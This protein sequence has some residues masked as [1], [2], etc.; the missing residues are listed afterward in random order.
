MLKW[1]KKK[2]ELTKI[3]DREIA[4]VIAYCNVTRVADKPYFT[5][6]GT[7]WSF[8]GSKLVCVHNGVMADISPAA[9]MFLNAHLNKVPV[10]SVH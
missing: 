8:K 7:V 10:V 4:N 3:P 9:H 1:F 6:N 5:I 2:P